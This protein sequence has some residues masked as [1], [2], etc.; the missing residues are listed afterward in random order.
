MLVEALSRVTLAVQWFCDG[1]KAPLREA[2]NA[3]ADRDDKIRAVLGAYASHIMAVS[4]ME[5]VSDAT[6]DVRMG[7]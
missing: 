6:R 4:P 5:F 2:R 1:L 3:E 7:T